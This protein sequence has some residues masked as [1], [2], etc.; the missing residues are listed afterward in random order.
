MEEW[1]GNVLSGYGAIVFNVFLGTSYLLYPLCGWMTEVYAVN[2][3]VIRLSFFVMFVSPFLIISAGII[4][5][6][7]NDNYTDNTYDIIT[8]TLYLLYVIFNQVGMGM[9]KSNAIQF[10]MDQMLDVPSEA[11]S[12]YIHWY[13][14]CAHIGGVVT[15]Y[16]L[17]GVYFISDNFGIRADVNKLLALLLIVVSTIRLF[18]YSFGLFFIN[19]SKK[20]FTIEIL[21]RNSL[22]LIHQ[23]LLYS[24]HHKY[25]ERR[26]AFTYWENYIPSRIDLGKKKYGGPFTYE[27]VEDVKCFFR[28]LLLMTSLFGF[29][30]IGN[31]VSLTNYIMCN[32]GCPSE[33]QLSLL[34]SIPQH[35]TILVIAIGV[36]ILECT[37]RYS[38][39]CLPTILNKISIGLIVSLLVL[40]VQTLCILIPGQKESSCNSAYGSS[41]VAECYNEIWEVRNGIINFTDPYNGNYVIYGSIIPL[42]LLGVAYQLVFLT[43]MEFICAQSPTSMKGILIGIWY[44]ISSI[45]YIIIYLDRQFIET[46]QWSIYTGIKGLCVLLSIVLFALVSKNYRFRERNEIVNE[47]CIVEHIY[48]NE[49]LLNASTS[50]V[51]STSD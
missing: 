8:Y 14:W 35:I 31:G 51:S 33:V 50:T 34:V 4:M 45:K 6:T 5:E 44:A 48:E 28:L 39:R 11:L 43:T 41:L 23:V 46:T 9:Y 10:G 12:S 15:V 37:K 24:Y 49:L 7:R 2:Y 16:V 13:L 17:V 21:S 40:A 47:Q 18:C 22:R 36:P 30:I 42:A 29:H 1:A 3:K 38:P 25:P 26:S 20:Y 19:W 32:Y 27:Q